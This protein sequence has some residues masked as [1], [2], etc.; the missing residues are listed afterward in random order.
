MGTKVV[1]GWLDRVRAGDP[2]EPGE[3]GLWTAF[4]CFAVYRDEPEGGFPAAPL[5]VVQQA[6]VQV[7]AHVDPLIH[8]IA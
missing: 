2:S 3:A 4:E 7:A 5:E 6:P 8:C 1:Q